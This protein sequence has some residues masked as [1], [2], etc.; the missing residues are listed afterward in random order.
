MEKDESQFRVLLQEFLAIT[1]DKSK[2]FHKY[3]MDNY[4]NKTSQWATCY[5]LWTVV[6]TNMFLEASHKVL[7]VIYLQHKQNRR[8]D[9]LLTILL[10]VARDKAF[11][12]FQ[13]LEKGKSTHRVCEVNKRHKAAEKILKNNT[14]NIT[15]IVPQKNWE[16]ESESQPGKFYTVV[17]EE[18]EQCGCQV[19]CSTC[20]ICTHL[21]SCS[22]LDSLLHHTVCK[23]C[24]L[25]AMTTGPYSKQSKQ[26]EDTDE[27]NCT[28]FSE[29]FHKETNTLASLKEQLGTMLSELQVKIMDSQDESVLLSVKTHST[30]SNCN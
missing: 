16:V 5:R 28:Y 6:N 10:K 29:M 25:V 26:K 24:H 20:G 23:H 2:D 8:V 3:F 1:Q 17:K 12:R 22:C 19:I 13:N 14:Q 9:Y 7:K 11:Q 18:Q 21:F 15:T 4:C 27:D 30:V